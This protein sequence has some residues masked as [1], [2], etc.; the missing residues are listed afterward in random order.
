MLRLDEV[1]SNQLSNMPKSENRVTL[2]FYSINPTCER[3]ALGKVLALLLA[4]TDVQKVEGV[5]EY[6]GV[7]LPVVQAG[8]LDGAGHDLF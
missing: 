7:G 1:K 3:L 6:G 4:P 2:N 8:G 5:L